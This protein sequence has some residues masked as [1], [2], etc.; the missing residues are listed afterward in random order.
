M[1]MWQYILQEI[2]EQ[3]HLLCQELVFHA[4]LQHSKFL[5]HIL[6]PLFINRKAL[7]MSLPE[8]FV[9]AACKY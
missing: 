8:L 6:K 1:L 9:D 7:V 2:K 4:P 3:K 5:T